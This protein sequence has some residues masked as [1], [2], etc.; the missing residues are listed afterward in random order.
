MGGDFSW[1]LYVKHT[2]DLQL[3][4]CLLVKAWGVGTKGNQMETNLSQ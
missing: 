1:A 4:M 2:Q 3:R